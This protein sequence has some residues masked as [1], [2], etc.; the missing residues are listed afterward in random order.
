MFI[1]RDHLTER[2]YW[3]C[4][5]QRTS[6]VAFGFFIA[7]LANKSFWNSNHFPFE[8]LQPGQ[9]LGRMGIVLLIEWGGSAAVTIVIAIAYRIN[10]VRQGGLV[11]MFGQSLPLAIVLAIF[12]FQALFVNLNVLN[13]CT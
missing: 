7:L 4:M 5:A 2:F 6:L 12:V 11:L 10:V 9:L 8:Q 1:R 3:L 13:F